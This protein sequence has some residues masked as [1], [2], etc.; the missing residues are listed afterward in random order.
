MFPAVEAARRGTGYFNVLVAF[1]FI[2]L[3]IGQVAT[4]G[5]TLPVYWALFLAAGHHN[6]KQA[7]AVISQRRAE[8]IVFGFLVGIVAPSVAMMSLQ[9]PKAIAFWQRECFSYLVA[10]IS[11]P[12]LICLFPACPLYFYIAQQLYLLV[13][14]QQSKV[15]SGYRTIKTFYTIVFVISA[16]THITYLVKRSAH[17]DGILPFFIPPFHPNRSTVMSVQ[18][19]NILQWDAILI[20][21]SSILASFWFADSITEVASL[22][23]WHAVMV[24]VGGPFASFTGVLLWRESKLN[25]SSG[26]Q[27]GKLK[28]VKKE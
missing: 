13:R 22:L 28:K 15:Q 14:R 18:A 8:S 20:T 27:S 6:V 4:L 16:A 21:G 1:P 19:I 25:G 26:V 10:A 5:A 23:I 17:P 3:L 11:W 24:P 2:T 9:T 7:D 12:V